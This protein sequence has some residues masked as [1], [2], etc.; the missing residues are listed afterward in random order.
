MTSVNSL[1]YGV[2]EI[3]PF[4]YN[5]ADSQSIRSPFAAMWSMTAIG[6]ELSVGPDW[7]AK[8]FAP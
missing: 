8:Q 6:S 5:P 7:T 4:C 1:P 2:A 3:D